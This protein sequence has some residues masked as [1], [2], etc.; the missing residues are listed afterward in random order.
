MTA[1]VLGYR[2]RMRPRVLAKIREFAA[3]KEVV[4]LKG[5][6]RTRRWLEQVAGRRSS[7]SET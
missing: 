2:R 1:Y 4:F 6:A 5:R 3:G 7:P